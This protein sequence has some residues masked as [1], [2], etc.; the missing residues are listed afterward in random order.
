M[1]INHRDCVAKGLIFTVQ[2]KRREKPVVR[3]GKYYENKNEV[4]FF[5]QGNTLLSKMFPSLLMKRFSISFICLFFRS[6][7]D[8]SM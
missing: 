3:V 2:K 6:F 5:Q 8:M 4:F 7:S 1:V